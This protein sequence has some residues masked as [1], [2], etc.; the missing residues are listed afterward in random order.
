MLTKKNKEI[1][2][3]MIDYAL[4]E[5]LPPTFEEIGIGTNLRSK[6][7]I[8]DHVHKL[9]REG[10]VEFVGGRYKINGIHYEIGGGT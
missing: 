1:L 6:S 3:F 8:Y 9:E 4:K 10:Y 5:G 2:D 7:S